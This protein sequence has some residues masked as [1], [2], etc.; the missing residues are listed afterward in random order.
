M[1]LENGLRYVRAT[2]ANGDAAGN[3]S[4]PLK[5][6]T[7]G[8][9]SSLAVIDGHP[10]IGFRSVNQVMYLWSAT[11]TGGQLADWDYPVLVDVFS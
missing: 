11:A 1:R 5:L 9:E 10:A 3:W 4:Q 6:H 2:T 8:D 7:S